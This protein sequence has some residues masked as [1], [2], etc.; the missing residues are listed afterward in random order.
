M[1]KKKKLTKQKIESEYEELI[2]QEKYQVFIM[3]CPAMFPLAVFHHPWFICNEK[4]KI[5]RWE[6]LFEEN[7]DR[8]WGHLHNNR[9]RPFQGI[10]IFIFSA[11]W[12]WRARL[13][14]TVEGESA[15]EMI[16]LIKSSRE[17]YPY[18]KKYFFA[19][20]NSNSYVHWVLSHFPEIQVSLPWNFFGKNV[21]KDGIFEE[22]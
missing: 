4:G 12:H 8:E 22:K 7:T 11:L 19:G 21:N 16:S 1:I 2:D 5:S 14:F 3:H 10:R 6:I 20:V 15:R 13:L 17:H 9:F 18:Y